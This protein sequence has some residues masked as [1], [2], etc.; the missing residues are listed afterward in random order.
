MK[1]LFVSFSFFIILTMLFTT[2]IF[3]NTIVGNPTNYTI[4]EFSTSTFEESINI[5]G[6]CDDGTVVTFDISNNSGET[7]YTQDVKKTGIFYKNIPLSLGKNYINLTFEKSGFDS[8]SEEYTVIRLSENVK[9]ELE[10]YT[11]VSQIN[12]ISW[13]PSN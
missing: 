3:A 12:V 13:L 4:N 7:S 2:S 8:V 9:K 11:C 1:K 5:T 10:E 6:N